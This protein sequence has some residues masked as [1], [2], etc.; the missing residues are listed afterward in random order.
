MA[1][2]TRVRD[3]V[4]GHGPVGPLHEFV[5]LVNR[6]S[7]LPGSRAKRSYRREMGRHP[8]P[9]VAGGL[10]HVTTRGNSGASIFAD[11]LDRGAFLNRLGHSVSRFEWQCLAFCLMGN[12]FHLAIKTPEPNIARGMRALNGWYAQRFNWRHDHRGH[13]FEAPY[14]AEFIEHEAHFL[15]VTRY[16]VRNPVRANICQLPEEWPWSSY[17]AMIGL[18]PAIPWL[19]TSELL[20]AFGSTAERAQQ[21]YR[22]FVE[23]GVDISR[24][25]MPADRSRDTARSVMARDQVPGHG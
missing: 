20:A 8:R 19:A 7:D 10:Y 14:H 25:D 12:H 2:T 6:T 1:S 24:Q 21:R 17:R 16:V 23:E 22:S 3:L 18:P 4:P 9:Q 15:E 11:D 5:L 13:L